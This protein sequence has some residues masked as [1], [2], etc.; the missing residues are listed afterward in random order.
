MNKKRAIILSIIAIVIVAG[1]VT[2]ALYLSKKSDD[3]EMHEYQQGVTTVDDS[4]DFG[5]CD[6]LKNTTISSALGAISKTME[7]PDN[8]GRGRLQNNDES[9]I[10]VYPFVSGGNINNGFNISNSFS[11]EVYEYISNSTKTADLAIANQHI[12]NVAVSG[13]GEEATFASIN[14]TST[15]TQSYILTVYS[16][17][18]HFTYTLNIPS[19]SNTFTDQ[20]AQAALV[21]IAKTVTY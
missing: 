18:K 2:T 10:C 19:S 6:L 17:M 20:T 7:G 1:A 15:T 9:Q 11:D 4:K 8:M 21:S 16:G 3:D 5:A 14:R 12:N 13:L